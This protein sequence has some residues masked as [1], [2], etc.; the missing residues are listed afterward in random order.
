MTADYRAGYNLGRS[1]AER[2]EELPKG[3]ARTDFERGRSADWQVGLV[4]GHDDVTK[5]NPVARGGLGELRG[6][7]PR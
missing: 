7:L 4:D 3:K 2:G 1:I 5:K 6:M